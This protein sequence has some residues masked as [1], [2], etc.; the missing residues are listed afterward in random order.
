MAAVVLS[1]MTFKYMLDSVHAA[2][3][4]AAELARLHVPILLIVAV[5][6]FI[7]GMVTGLAVGFVGTSF[8]IVLASVRALPD[9]G[10]ILPYA[11]LAYAFGHLGQMCSPLHVC[12]V[13][14]NQYFKTGFGPVY[15]R[16]LPSVVVCALFAF[17]YFFLLRLFL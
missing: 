17:A 11:M 16:I 1:V 2:E 7:A 5:L 4:M 15:R 10:S 14:S 8:P 9:T 6:P 13:V 12:H 3:Q